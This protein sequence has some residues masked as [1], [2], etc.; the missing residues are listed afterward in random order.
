MYS[1]LRLQIAQSNLNEMPNL[2]TDI[3]T[4]TTHSGDGKRS[5]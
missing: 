5:I 1:T 2:D 4:L 3:W